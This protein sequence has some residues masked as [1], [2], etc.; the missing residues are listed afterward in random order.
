MSTE[1][2]RNARDS[3]FYDP[4]SAKDVRSSGPSHSVISG[5]EAAARSDA[6]VLVV[7]QSGTPAEHIAR[8]LHEKSVARSGPFI[9]LNCGAVA[10]EALADQIFGRGD[11]SG[12]GLLDLAAGGTLFLN[13]IGALSAYAQTRLLLDLRNATNPERTANAAGLARVRIIAS[14]HSPLPALA[15]GGEFDLSTSKE[16]TVI[17]ISASDILVPYSNGNG[18]TRS[19][20]MDS[21]RS[22]VSHGTFSISSEAAS[23]SEDVLMM[24]FTEA[25]ALAVELFDKE[26]LSAAL[27]RNSG[28]I[29]RTARSLGLH[30]QSLQKLMGRRGIKVIRPVSAPRTA[31]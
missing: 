5:V 29:A 17:D 9:A 24:P 21:E 18:A 14:T 13:D 10:Q 31:V 7:G 22:T 25:R 19:G 20:G 8:L 3:A 11:T 6:P 23:I 16:F 2:A 15:D 12:A 27:A 4:A 26:F 28:N 1:I 30:R